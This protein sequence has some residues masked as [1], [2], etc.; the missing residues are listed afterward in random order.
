MFTHQHPLMNH[1]VLNREDTKSTSLYCCCLP[2]FESRASGG[3]DVFDFFSRMWIFVSYYAVNRP[4]AISSI[5]QQIVSEPIQNRLAPRVSRIS[6]TSEGKLVS[7]MAMRLALIWDRA[8]WYTV[9]EATK[10]PE[11]GA[12]ARVL[13]Y[14]TIESY[15]AAVSK[16]STT[17]VENR[18]P[19]LSIEQ[20]S[21]VKHMP[22]SPARFHMSAFIFRRHLQLKIRWPS[23]IWRKA[24][25]SPCFDAR[26]TSFLCSAWSTSL[27]DTFLVT[28]SLA[29]CRLMT[30][31]A[32]S[33]SDLSPSFKASKDEIPFSSTGSTQV[34]VKSST[35][36][37]SAFDANSRWRQDPTLLSA[38]ERGFLFALAFTPS[39]ILYSDLFNRRRTRGDQLVLDVRVLYS[40]RTS[41]VK[42]K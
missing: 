38:F 15:S 28:L 13:W 1:G 31:R 14:N 11:V 17:L 37:T 34:H 12:T 33:T 19:H 4:K 32:D 2:R 3:E 21:P 36:Y 26:F 20:T 41:F 10:N 25:T 18:F 24:N 23:E 22:P 30:S 27:A 8:N 42:R 35:A 39:R 29:D 5:S 9:Y 7:F 40:A 16:S 6:G